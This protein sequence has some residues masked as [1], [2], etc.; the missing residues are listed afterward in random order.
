MYSWPDSDH[1]IIEIHDTKQEYASVF[2]TTIHVI[3]LLSVVDAL[4]HP[5]YLN[6]DGCALSGLSLSFWLQFLS[7]DVIIRV[8]KAGFHIYV[9][10]GK[11]FITYQGV[12]KK[13]TIERTCIPMSVFF[14]TATWTDFDGL[15]YYENGKLVTSNQSFE[16][17]SISENLDDVITVGY[18]KTSSG[19]SFSSLLIDDLMIWNVSL[20]PDQ[21]NMIYSDGT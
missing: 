2:S 18:E 3:V 16:L 11:F 14:L 21:I 20:S 9:D 12:N 5:C 8:G 19:E 7:G 6:P 1:F 4:V 17:S 15:S 13:W 10:N